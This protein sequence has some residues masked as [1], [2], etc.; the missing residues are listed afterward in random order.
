M[1]R[2]RTT[3][4]AQEETDIWPA[5]SRDS[6]CSAADPGCSVRKVPLPSWYKELAIEADRM[7]KRSLPREYVISTEELKGQ[8]HKG[9]THRKLNN[10]P[11][12]TIDNNERNSRH[13][14]RPRQ[15][16]ERLVTRRKTE[17]AKMMKKK[18]S[19]IGNKTPV[20]IRNEPI[21]RANKSVCAAA[22]V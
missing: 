16:V 1:C 2:F 12:Q 6:L 10:W 11:E 8:P 20:I 7:L 13:T 3:R 18:T 19:G 17:R 9:S 15:F 21:W 4:F 14:F 5:K 22:S